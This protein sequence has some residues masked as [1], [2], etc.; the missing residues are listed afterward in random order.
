MKRIP[1]SSFSSFSALFKD[2]TE[3]FERLAPFF[4][5]DFRSDNDLKSV[6]SA[7]AK[8]H[9]DRS[10]V[11]DAI[12]NQAAFYGL[13]E[14]SEP[15][16]EKLANP[17]SVAIVTGQQLGLYGGPLYTLFKIITAIQ[18]AARY[19]RELG[20]PAVPVFWLEGEDHDFE[21]IASAAFLQG[22][23]PIKVTYAPQNGSEAKKAIG[24]MVVSPEIEQTLSALEDVLQPTDFKDDLVALMRKA[25]A[26]GK[27]MLQAFVTVI[28]A[29]V[30]EGNV[31][32]VSPDDAKLKA[33]SSD[34]FKRELNDFATSSEL[35]SST[36]EKLPEGHHVQVQTKPT[37]LFLHTENGR[38]AIDATETGFTTRDGRNLALGELEQLLSEDPGQFSPNVVLRPLMQD[39]VLPTAAYV[40]GPGEVAYFAQFKSL[41]TWAGLQMPIIYPR[42]SAT[43]MEKRID[44]IVDKFSLSV[45]AFAEQFDRLFR[46]VV[47]DSSDVD[48]E[49]AFKASST[50]LHK[51]INEI[52][53][54]VEQVDRS[55]VKSSDAL[56]NE[57][58]K[59][60]NRLKD[61]VLKAERQQQDVVK[62]QLYR[63]SSN[64]FP[65]EIPQERALSP[66]YFLNKYGPTF[67]QTLINTLDLDTT[68]HQV[69]EP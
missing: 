16:L 13:G 4:A 25:Y 42:A 36:S 53:P 33:F 11:V 44:K 57:M 27:T 10:V 28:N 49:G 47:I 52:K 50:H 68:T 30:G 9:P 40:A 21:E 35:L 69:I 58:M 17:V 20:I 6:A 65:F 41:Y 43:I 8:N 37:N 24:R 22:D 31:L 23:D 14:E 12:R 60:W 29:Y 46:Q 19:E 54:V 38:V 56:R 63:A 59:E 26:P 64:L 66:L 1:F 67:G 32:F 51:A 62:G 7:V 48:V 2:Y 15:L 39:T 18:L 5:G 61:R 3:H 34:L 55:L 45:P